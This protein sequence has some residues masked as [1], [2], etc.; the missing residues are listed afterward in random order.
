MM[1]RYC[2]DITFIAA[3]SADII[4]IK[5]TPHTKAFIH[6]VNALFYPLFL[7]LHCVLQTMTLKCRYRVPP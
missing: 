5:K 7:L 6:N 1:S 4:S 3:F 2:K